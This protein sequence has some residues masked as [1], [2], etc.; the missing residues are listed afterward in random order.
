VYKPK[1][2]NLPHQAGASLVEYAL[3]VAMIA[4]IAIVAVRSFGMKRNERFSEISSAI[5]GNI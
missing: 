3:L 5:D 1:T 4:L 2:H